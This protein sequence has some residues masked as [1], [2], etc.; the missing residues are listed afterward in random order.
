MVMRL[1]SALLV[2][3]LLL[4]GSIVQ[5]EGC[6]EALLPPPPPDCRPHPPLPGHEHHRMRVL[7]QLTS[8]QQAQLDQLL[9][10]ERDHAAVIMQKME[11]NRH[12]LQQA[13][14]R[15]PFDE[16]AITALAKL[17]SELQTE[18]LVSHIRT[19]VRIRSLFPPPR[20]Q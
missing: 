16:A 8:E 4:G 17:Q 11:E 10:N 12:A 15:E 7:P 1:L 18:L 9:K 5:A 6:P 19:Q 2:A 14:D 20:N 3:G 13:A